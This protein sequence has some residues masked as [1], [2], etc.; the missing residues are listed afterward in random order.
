[1]SVGNQAEKPRFFVDLLQYQ[2]EIGNI[3]CITDHT[4]NASTIYPSLIGLTPTKK[5]EGFYS[6]NQYKSVY[7]GFKKPISIPS[8]NM[9]VGILGHKFKENDFGYSISFNTY[10][11]SASSDT[12]WLNY[13]DSYNWE[14]LVDICNGS[15]EGGATEYDGWSISSFTPSYLKED[16]CMIRLL[17]TNNNFDSSNP[18]EWGFDIGN[19]TIGM[20]YE[21]EF[22]ADLA[23]TQSRIMDGVKNKKTKGGST[24]SVVNYT[25]PADWW[26][27]NPF[28][29]T[30]PGST[31]QVG[32]RLGRRSWD[33]AF[34]QLSDRFYTDGVPNGVF[35]AN[36]MINKFNPDSVNGN[37]LS[38]QDYDSSS[39][40]FNYNMEND[41]SLY[42]TLYH[43]TLG[44]TLPFIFSPSQDNSPQNFAICRFDKPGFKVTQKSYKKFNV[45]MKIHESW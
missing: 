31:P 32:A 30:S 13:T 43:H 10:N 42:S 9:F 11:S 36:E 21:P 37:Y 20:I 26:T 27:G 35:P 15:P 2:Y 23:V 19:V 34:S 4:I 44:G 22:H 18:N 39:G 41:N 8:S 33:V 6:N 1:M 29:L 17:I 28:E 12:S 16:I 40:M 3:G 5:Y 38:D 24:Y 14:G 45:K 25:K 7:I